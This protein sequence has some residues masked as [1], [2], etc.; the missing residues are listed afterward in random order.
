MPSVG[1]GSLPQKPGRGRAVVDA[2][3]PLARG[4]VG[5][6]PLT[7][8]TGLPWNAAGGG[9][10]TS[11]TL[12][13]A[14]SSR[15]VVLQNAGAGANYVRIN[16]PNGSP[17]SVTGTAISFGAWVLPTAAANQC[18]LAKTGGLSSRQYSIALLNTS[19][20]FVSL[21]NGVPVFN[22]TLTCPWTAGAWNHIFVTYD[23]ATVRT[24]TNGVPGSTGA[25]TAAIVEYAGSPLSFGY[26]AGSS[27]NPLNGLVDCPAVWRRALSAAE[28]KAFASN[29]YQLF[30][31]SVD[32]A[33]LGAR[34]ASLSRRTLSGRVGSRG[35]A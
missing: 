2:T 24:Y 11:N 25:A 35:V 8:V 16:V 20:V 22:A 13:W 9:P 33:W 3:N 32:V 19:S 5:F 17:L 29:P 23:G 34:A 1:G 12:T 6:W 14:A 28:V 26:D 4:L 27:A 18:V 15:G 31:P 10:A 21:G 7:E 30:R